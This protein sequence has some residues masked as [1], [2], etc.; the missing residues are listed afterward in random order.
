M[1]ELKKQRDA[2][3]RPRRGAY[4]GRQCACDRRCRPYLPERD[5]RQYAIGGHVSVDASSV[6]GDPDA[7]KEKVQQARRAALAPG[8]PSCPDRKAEPCA[9]RRKRKEKAEEIRSASGGILGASVSA[10]TEMLA[11]ADRAD[12]RRFRLVHGRHRCCH[13]GRGLP[14]AERTGGTASA[15]QVPMPICPCAVSCPQPR[16]PEIRASPPRV[17]AALIKPPV[18]KLPFSIQWLAPCCLKNSAFR[19]RWRVR[20]SA[21]ASSGRHR[22]HPVPARAGVQPATRF[23]PP[24]S[25]PGPGYC[26]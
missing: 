25:G 1:R 8:E 15:P 4:G 16:F 20:R 18:A 12:P 6:P 19:G 5:G 11:A 7:T 13:V 2:E 3:A 26:A 24:R 9:G 17:G 14:A 10:G 21:L 22:Q 23:P